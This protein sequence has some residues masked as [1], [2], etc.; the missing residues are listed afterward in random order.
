MRHSAVPLSVRLPEGADAI[1]DNLVKSLNISKGQFIRNAIIE[2]IED[3]LDIRAIE[4]VIARNEK[5]YSLDE[6]KR[7]L[8]LED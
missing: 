2:K 3:A 6:V 1:L 5:T 7:E 8:G 4:E